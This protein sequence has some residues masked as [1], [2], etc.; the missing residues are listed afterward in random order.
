MRAWLTQH[1]AALGGALRRLV[2]APLGTVAN[3]LAI[4]VAL[5]LPVGAY[6]VVL[7]VARATRSIDQSPEMTVFL[8]PSATRAQAESLAPSLK[9][10]EGV[11][12]VKFVPRE[13]AL[14]KLVEEGAMSDIAGALGQNPLPDAYAL[15]FDSHDALA[16]ERYAE[17]IRA[18]QHVD[19]VQVDSDWVRRVAAALKLG[20][21]AALGLAVLLAFALVAVTFNTIRLQILTQKDEIEVSQL[22]GATAGFIGRPFQYYGLALGALGGL[23]A[24]A[25]VWLDLWLLRGAVAELATLYR[26]DFRL[27][28]VPWA[29]AAAVVAFAAFLGWL[30]ATFSVAR[31]LR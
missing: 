23:A 25:V 2:V 19:L 14:K 1:R 12:I 13:A 7:N 11:A 10:L 22:L 4:A 31:H 6:T 9:A 17:A 20:R 30:G 28:M 15:G 27:S 5:S 18:M 26:S 16:L 3:L 24:L 21:L 8:K 29:D